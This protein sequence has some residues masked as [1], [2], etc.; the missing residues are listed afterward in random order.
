MLRL[1]VKEIAQE[2]KL[3]MNMLS[4]R[5]EVAYNIIKDCYRNPYRVINSET[6]NKIAKGLGV[7][8]TD[9]LENVSEEF[10]AKEMAERNI[11]R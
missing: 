9:I 10:A 7:S 4:H 2:K 6:I 11:K 3:S 1:R 8:A 5:S